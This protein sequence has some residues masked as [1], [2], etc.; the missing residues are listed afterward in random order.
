MQAVGRRDCLYPLYLYDKFVVNPI[1]VTQILMA[2]LNDASLE[3]Q[4]RI[5]QPWLKDCCLKLGFFGS[6]EQPS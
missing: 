6:E 2:D 4:S 5:W 3:T 1:I